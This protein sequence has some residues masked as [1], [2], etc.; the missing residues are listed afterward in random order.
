MVLVLLDLGDNLSDLAPFAEVY[1][2]LVLVQEVRVADADVVD[3]GEESAKER[4]TRRIDGA[5]LL[6]ILAAVISI[7][8]VAH[9]IKNFLASERSLRH[10]L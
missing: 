10:V 2:L 7:H 5:Q 4:D 9:T 6:Q 1:Q 3:V 8:E